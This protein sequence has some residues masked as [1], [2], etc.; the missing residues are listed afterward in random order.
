MDKIVRKYKRFWS[1]KKAY[2]L[3]GTFFA[4]VSLTF[5]AHALVTVS[6]FGVFGD[7]GVVVDGSGTLNLGTASS[8]AVVIGSSSTPVTIP[9]SLAVNG[10]TVSVGNAAL[11]VPDA[12]SIFQHATDDSH[13]GIIVSDAATNS[14]RLLEIN[15]IGAATS[16]YQNYGLDIHN[17]PGANMALVGHNYSTSAFAQFDNTD[18]GTILKLRDADN[19]IINPGRFG[20]GNFIELWGYPSTPVAGGS[21]QL[22]VLD[23]TL[24][25]QSTAARPWT[26][27]AASGNNVDSLKIIQQQNAYG[28]EIVQGSPN[29]AIQISHTGAAVAFNLSAAPGANYSPMIVSTTG[30]FGAQ[31]STSGTGN[32]AYALLVAHNGTS[33]TSDALRV[34]NK[35]TGLGIDLQNSS[36]TIFSVDAIGVI[37]A[38][39]GSTGHA[40]CWKA[41]GVIG[42]CSSVVAS[43][44]TCTCN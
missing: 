17:L 37:T 29:S 15:H 13:S 19:Q 11:P 4:F 38:A 25:F 10:G 18:S 1:P 16:G 32:S 2:L 14:G 24:T 7:A 20:T 23:N 30:S 39:G 12:L 35:G 26:F 44:G 42:Y 43:D 21:I 41:G 40:T 9:G 31:F 34:V 8:T 5:T 36:T 33:G 27:A 22:G 28:L 3:L 6:N